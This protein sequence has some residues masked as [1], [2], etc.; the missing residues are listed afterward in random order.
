MAK[1]FFMTCVSFYV[2]DIRKADLY[3]QEAFTINKEGVRKDG[4][5]AFSLWRNEQF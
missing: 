5:I 3:L 4:K 2:N 1:I